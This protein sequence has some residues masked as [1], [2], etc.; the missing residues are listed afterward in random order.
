LQNVARSPK[1]RHVAAPQPA[2][3]RAKKIMKTISRTGALPFFAPFLA[4]VSLLAFSSLRANAQEPTPSGTPAASASPASSPSSSAAQKADTEW[5]GISVELTSLSKGEGD[6]VTIKFKYTNNGSKPVNVAK[7]GQFS[8]DNIAEKVYY[9]D[10]KNKK[11]YLVIKDSEGHA[12]ASNMKY[13]ELEAGASKAGWL[14]LPA[15][16]PDVTAISVYLPGAPPF[17]GVAIGR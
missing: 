14:K 4:V 6:T 3:R 12:L 5:E 7:E 13:L 10:P 15:P 1:I 11:K 2:A 17:E 8:H 16:P 9:I